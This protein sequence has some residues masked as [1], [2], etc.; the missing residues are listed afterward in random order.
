MTGERLS[1]ELTHKG[2]DYRYSRTM[3]KRL[4]A[5]RPFKLRVVSYLVALRLRS[6]TKT[7]AWEQ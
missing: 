2:A 5:R 6:K 7:H 3:Y 4:L 1:E